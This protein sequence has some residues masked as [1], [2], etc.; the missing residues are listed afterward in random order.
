MSKNKYNFEPEICE[1]CGQA[2]TYLLPID[3]GTALIVKAVARAIRLKGINAIHPVKEME[4]PAKGWNYGMAIND[5]KLTSNQIGNFTRA[6]VH[7]L[8]AC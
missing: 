1:C 5:G 7:G 2:Q 3:W 8:I 6:R 4:V